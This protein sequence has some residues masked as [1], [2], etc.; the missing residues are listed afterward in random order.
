MLLC[1]L[2]TVFGQMGSSIQEEYINMILFIKELLG[3]NTVIIALVQC[4]V[5]FTPEYSLDGYRS[6]VSSIQD[7]YMSLLKRY[8]E[9]HHDWNVA[10]RIYSKLMTSICRIKEYTHKHRESLRRCNVSQV[11]PLRLEIVSIPP[12]RR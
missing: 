8:L 9:V 3:P 5:I 4:I 2:N 6:L 12:I 10:L 1:V 11:E 7:K